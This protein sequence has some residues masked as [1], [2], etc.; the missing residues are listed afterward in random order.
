MSRTAVSGLRDDL[1]YMQFLPDIQKGTNVH[2]GRGTQDPI[3]L[4][5]PVPDVPVPVPPVS[6]YRYPIQI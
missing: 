6:F 1:K 5:L 3:A 4:V 2:S